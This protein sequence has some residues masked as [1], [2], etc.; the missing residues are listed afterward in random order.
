MTEEYWYRYEDVRYAPPVD[1]FDNPMGVSRVEL[2]LWQFPVRKATPKGV[3]LDNVGAGQ[4][5]RFVLR[6][7]HKRFA[8]PTLEEARVSYIARKNRQIL[9]L[10]AALRRAEQGR[11]LAVKLQGSPPASVREVFGEPAELL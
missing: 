1:E 6:D 2:R 3:W 8:C 11:E 7:G 4:G 5:G 9:I 10:Q